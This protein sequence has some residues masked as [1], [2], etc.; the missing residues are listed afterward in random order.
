MQRPHLKKNKQK[1]CFLRER[2]QIF[3]V[4]DLFLELS[5]EAICFYRRK[6]MACLLC[7]GHHQETG[8]GRK[9]PGSCYCLELSLGRGRSMS[10]PIT[11]TQ[12][13]KEPA[14]AMLWGSGG[15]V[16]VENKDPGLGASSPKWRLQKTLQNRSL[17]LHI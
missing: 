14:N 8:N 12:F 6:V 16:R 15:R 7:A 5:Q 4:S 9:K 2:Y 3:T 11:K 17:Q 10:E 1:L 13:Q